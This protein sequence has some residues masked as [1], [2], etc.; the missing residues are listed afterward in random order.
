MEENKNETKPVTRYDR[1]IQ[2]RKEAAAKQK[3]KNITSIITAAVIILLLV[4]V[5]IATPIIKRQSVK[6]EFIQVGSHSI[7]QL[8]YN[9]YYSTT[10]NG[11]LN[12]NSWLLSYLG[13]DTSKSFAE[14]QYSETMTWQDYFN[15]ITVQSIAEY[16]TLLDDAKSKQ[17]TYDTTED[18]AA[19]LETFKEAAAEAGVTTKV[20]YTTLYGTYATES[21]LKE[22]VT[23]ALLA[24]AYYQHLLEQNAPNDA[25]IAAYYEEN[26]NS[27]D[28]VDYRSLSFAASYEEGADEEAINA[29]YLATKARADE[30]L[31]RLNAGED[32]ATLAPE[33]TTKTDE[34][35]NAD[36]TLTEAATYSATNSTMREW[37]FHEARTAGDT[38]VLEDT[39]TN[40]CYVVSF[41][42][43]AFDEAKNET[44]A[45]TIASN[46]TAEYVET[47]RASYTLNDLH[48]KLN[49]P[50]ATPT[51]TPTA[52]PATAAE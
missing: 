40:T 45:N 5:M 4:G 39:S 12:T 47:L 6:A 32:F 18:Y 10:V 46:R 14:Q 25:D 3:K 20:Y 31:S 36:P 50:E 7:T 29:A 23:E 1:K 38:A 2:A 43:R 13:L 52:A 49:I 15:S 17:F 35:E 51:P 44:I 9:Y 28:T 33:Y 48:G 19:Y 16:M 24:Q 34:T 11:F 30:M 42:A 21:A 27:Y 37:L 26:K 22:Y 41:I 8:E